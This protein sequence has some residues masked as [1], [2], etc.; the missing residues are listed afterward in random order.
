[1]LAVYAQKNLGFYKSDATTETEALLK[2]GKDIKNEGKALLE[3]M[4]A[5]YKGSNSQLF[6][7]Y[8]FYLFEMRGKSAA[9]IVALTKGSNDFK[10]IFEYQI[11]W[12][13][14]YRSPLNDAYKHWFYLAAV[15]ETGHPYYCSEGSFNEDECQILIGYGALNSRTMLPKAL[16]DTSMSASNADYHYVAYVGFYDLETGKFANQE[17]LNLTKDLGQSRQAFNALFKKGGDGKQKY[18]HG[19]IMHTGLQGS[20]DKKTAMGSYAS[21]F[22][23]YRTFVTL[24]QKGVKIYGDLDITEENL[25]L[26]T[27][28]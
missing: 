16:V 1:M 14:R 8:T 19:V 12:I 23:V 10:K 15:R 28:E 4:K 20:W 27:K 24:V 17:R 9:P 7:S 13:L 18:N 25:Q 6:K 3:K 2:T 21:K 26:R 5:L 11:K 22:D